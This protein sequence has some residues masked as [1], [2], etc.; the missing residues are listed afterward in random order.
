LDFYGSAVN[1]AARVAGPARADDGPVTR[2]V[3]DP[4]G[5]R[6]PVQFDLAGPA[7][8]QNVSEPVTLYRARS[9]PVQR[10]DATPR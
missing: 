3:V 8:L 9:S 6:L 5:D 10:A 1:V 4:A 2:T 7:R